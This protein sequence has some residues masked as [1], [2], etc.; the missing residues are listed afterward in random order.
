MFIFHSVAIRQL[1]PRYSKINIW[2]AILCLSG[3]KDW[4]TCTISKLRNDRK[5][6]Y[7]F[8]IPNRNDRCGPQNISMTRSIPYP[9]KPWFLTSPGGIGHASQFFFFFLGGGGESISLIVFQ[10]YQNVD[11]LWNITF[12]FW[13]VAIPVKYECDS[14]HQRDSATKD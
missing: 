4:C 10:N 13:Q 2:W 7:I 12:T 14:K 11:Y 6:K 5:C 8:M 1:S 9:F 3:G